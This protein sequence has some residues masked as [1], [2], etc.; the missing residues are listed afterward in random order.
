MA[1]CLMKSSTPSLFI[2]FLDWRDSR[3]SWRIMAIRTFS[4]PHSTLRYQASPSAW[5]HDVVVDIRGVGSLSQLRW[6]ASCVSVTDDLDLGAMRP[7]LEATNPSLS[8]YLVTDWLLHT[9]NCERPV[10]VPIARVPLNETAY[11]EYRLYG[12]R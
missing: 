9:L 11:D 8:V 2:H 6:V 7:P 1:I 5:R 4:S 10:S 12:G 3:G